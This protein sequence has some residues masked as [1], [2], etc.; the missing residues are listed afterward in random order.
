[1]TPWLLD[2]LCDPVS[3]APLQLLDAVYE[4]GSIVSG[5]LVG[6][7]GRRYPIISGIPR[8]VSDQSLH[9]SVQSFGREWNYFNFTDFKH[10]WLTHTVSNT[11]GSTEAFAGRVIVD[12]GG[13]SGAQTLWMLESGA[14][15]V[16]TLELSGSVDDVVQ[17]NLRPTGFRNF[18]VVQ[19]SIDQPPLRDRSIDGLVICHNVIQHTPSVEK[20]AKALFAIVAPGGEFVF[21]CYRLIVDDPFRWTRFHLIYE[22]L[23]AILSKRSFRLTLLYSQVMASLRLIPLFGW[24]LEKLGF[25]AQG[26]VPPLPN[27]TWIGRLKRRWKATALNTFDGFGSH[28]YQHF[29]KDS[30]IRSLLESLQPDSAKIL[31][32]ERYFEQPPPIGI[33]IRVL[34]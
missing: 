23:R 24:I 9:Q 3:K 29:K 19:C 14:K 34:R 16:I 21:N 4:D 8:F 18:D 31:N 13:G 32:T 10:H 6:G 27:E 15:H 25:C 17:R 22:P 26:D 28:Q 33:A 30:E 20:T 1:M 7:D 5:T 2:Y 11:F 12:A